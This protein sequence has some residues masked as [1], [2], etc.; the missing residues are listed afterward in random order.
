MG[1]ME[2]SLLERSP[3]GSSQVVFKLVQEMKTQKHVP[4]EY[5]ETETELPIT[6]YAVATTSTISHKMLS[7]SEWFP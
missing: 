3:L 2:L 5:Q 4:G 7:L 6:E 1:P